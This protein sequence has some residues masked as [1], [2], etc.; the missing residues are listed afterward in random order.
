MKM[1]QQQG[2]FKKNFYNTFW[3]EIAVFFPPKQ[4]ICT[5]KTRRWHG[6]PASLPI[7][8]MWLNSIIS[9]MMVDGGSA[10]VNYYT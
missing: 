9:M 5:L 8:A 4:S 10:H 3:K 7:V 2:A 6:P 1:I